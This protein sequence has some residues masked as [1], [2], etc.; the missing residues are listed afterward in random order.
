M[1]KRGKRTLT[2][3]VQEI[4]V[5]KRLRNDNI[6]LSGEYDELL[7][8]LVKEA[9]AH[10]GLSEELTAVHLRRIGVMT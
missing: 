4:E 6:I 8:P 1:A 5:L 7:L 3:I 9:R 10:L 2:K